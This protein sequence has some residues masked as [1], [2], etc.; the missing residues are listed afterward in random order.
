MRHV[1][2]SLLA[3]GVMGCAAYLGGGNR[4]LF[5]SGRL[6]DPA[7]N[8]LNNC[9]TGVERD[10]LVDEWRP[11]ASELREVFL[12]SPLVDEH[13]IIIQCSGYEER[14]VTATAQTDGGWDVDGIRVGTNE[15]VQLGE[16]IL[17]PI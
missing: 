2:R 6:M 1:P 15:T 17:E 4:A 3:L 12:L 14:K 8:P 9:H 7:G 10:G 5:L 11:V 13:R 16:V